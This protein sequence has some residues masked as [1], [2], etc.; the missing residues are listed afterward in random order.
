MPRNV[1]SGVH[2]ALISGSTVHPI[3]KLFR[4]KTKLGI[5]VMRKNRG[6]GRGDEYKNCL[7]S[8]LSS[9]FFLI[10]RGRLRLKN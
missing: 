2:V 7:K 8:K 4:P 3:E 1:I 9:P 6:K 10:I 5:V